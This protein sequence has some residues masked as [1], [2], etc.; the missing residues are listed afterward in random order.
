MVERSFERRVAIVL[1][2]QRLPVATGHAI[3]PSGNRSIRIGEG[4]QMSKRVYNFS[5]GPAVLPLPVLQAAERAVV[6]LPGQ[7]MSILEIS[8][9]SK[10]FEA[11]L[12]KPNRY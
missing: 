6:E 3:F 2:Q 9:R 5:A 7:G 12:R 10:A 1:A 8:H 11:V 4:S